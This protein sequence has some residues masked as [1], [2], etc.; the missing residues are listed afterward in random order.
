MKINTK[1]TKSYLVTASS[2]AIVVIFIEVVT[3]LTGLKK[4]K[5]SP[6]PK[7]LVDVV[8]KWPIF[9]ISGVVTFIIVFYWQKNRS[10][11]AVK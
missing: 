2:W 3:E 9:L 1:V 5:L 6:E 7:S 10:S 11:R 4:Y 8:D